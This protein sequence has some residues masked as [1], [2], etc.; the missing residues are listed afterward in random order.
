MSNNPDINIITKATK[1]PKVTAESKLCR[2]K[3]CDEFPSLFVDDINFYFVGNKYG[4]KATYYELEQLL[5]EGK[6]RVK[7]S[8]NK[9]KR[10]KETSELAVKLKDMFDSV[11]QTL[12]CSCCYEDKSINGFGQCSDGHLICYSCI[13]KHA[14]DTIY[15]KLSC[16]VGCI[17]SQEKCYGHIDD[18]ILSQILD[19]RVFS[20]YKTLKNLDEIK[21]LCIDDINIKLC[22]HCNAGTDIGE[23]EQEILVCL[24]CFKDTC[25]K[26]NQVAHPGVNCFVLGNINR[27]QRQNIEDKMS[28]AVI[29]RCGNCS[30]PIVKDEGCNKVTCLCGHFIC[31]VCK[32]NVPKEV[33]YSHFCTEHN[34]QKPNCKPCHLW[35][36]NLSNR[37]IDA[38]KE[39]YN[40]DTKKLIDNLL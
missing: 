3:L 33:G 27:G 36:T 38:V 17:N 29:I 1:L 15:Q 6:L 25:L 11:K 19:I 16:K 31:Y 23:T 30:N 2:D 14:E 28:E 7:K 32:Q 22:Q 40:E 8:E 5:Q 20:E 26:C 9:T 12:E 37:I 4:Y 34:C 10:V 13:K 18:A 21:E 24:E 35:D 39:D